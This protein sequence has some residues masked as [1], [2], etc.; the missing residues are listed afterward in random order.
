MAT[1]KNSDYDA[2]GSAAGLGFSRFGGGYVDQKWRPHLAQ[3]QN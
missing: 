3:T 2:G 1:G